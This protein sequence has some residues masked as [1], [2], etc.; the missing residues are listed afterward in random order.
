MHTGKAIADPE[1]WT[2]RNYGDEQTMK[3]VLLLATLAC[4]VAGCSTGPS[5]SVRPYATNYSPS[6]YCLDHPDKIKCRQEASHN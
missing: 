5:A 3:N 6:V 1:R 2:S 4:S